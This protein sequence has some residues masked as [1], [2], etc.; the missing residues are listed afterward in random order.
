MRH[1]LI[2][3]G[4]LLLLA[5]AEGAEA[6]A[7]AEAEAADVRGAE[8][9]GQLWD[10]PCDLC[11]ENE[12]C[13]GGGCDCLEGFVRVEG[14]CQDVDECATDNGGCPELCENSPGAYV[15]MN[16]GPCP[17]CTLCADEDTILTAV[18]EARRHF[19]VLTAELPDAPIEKA[20]LEDTNGTLSLAFDAE[21]VPLLSSEAG[22]FAAA[23]RL[24]EGRVVAFSG[25]D[26]LSSGARSTLLDQPGV[27]GLIH[28]AADWVRGPAEGRQLLVDNQA[29]ADLL[30]DAGTVRVATIRRAEGL[31][32]IRDWSA[33][34][35]QEVDVAV[36]QV[37][38]WGTSHVEAADAQAL[39][40]FVRGGGGL[41]IAGSALHWSWWLDWTA[42]RFQGDAILEGSGLSWTKNSVRA[43]DQ[44]RFVND[45]LD[46]PIALWCGYVQGEPVADRLMPR[47]PPLFEAA[48]AE[49]LDAEVG[50]G[51]RRLIAETPLL[52]APR[53]SPAGLLSAEVGVGLRGAAW[54]S[55]HPWSSVFPG[56][57][58]PAA[59]RVSTTVTVN[60]DW[61][62]G[63][64]LGLYAPP[65]EVVEVQVAEAHIAQGL[66][67]RVGE[68]HDDN[69]FLEH[70]EAWERSPLLLQEG[71]LDAT[72]VRVGSGIGG[73]L[74]LV[75]PPEHPGGRI[76]LSVDGAVR[77]AVYTHGET[78]AGDF[79]AALDGGA[80]RALLQTVGK[81]RMEVPTAAARA[82]PDPAEVMDFWTG[83]YESHHSLAREPAP[84]S[85]ESHWL[86]D[87]QVGWGYANA[88]A[89]R[90]NFPPNAV[91]WAL[92]T[93]GDEDWWLFA[94]ELGHQFQTADWSG[95]DITEVAVNLFSM[96]T[97]NAYLNGGGA[98][99]TRGFMENRVDH[100]ALREARWETA[101][102]FGKLELYRQLVF[103]FGWPVFEQVFASYYDPAF[104]RETFGGFM[105]G[106]ALR[107]S[108]IARQDI[109][110]FLV[111]WGYPL[112]AEARRAVQSFGLP[113]WLPPGW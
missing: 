50:L 23:A 99:E 19:H 16:A 59:G 110:P 68:L 106:F 25:Q 47:L 18:A 17:G 72:T 46:T 37:N 39:N 75:V 61:K 15:C 69:R 33:A 100:A 81:V 62:L 64:P 107:F 14:R 113:E 82:V 35:L 63:R 10:V 1:A 70:I 71:P 52:P 30:A 43:V 36:V 13:R 98:R 76:E 48:H 5:C 44:A 26:F 94:H 73:T 77:Q 92:R 104:P 90:I 112:S 85:Y 56:Q 27:T 8:D 78:S 95:G 49:G 22:I 89:E 105:D 12:A 9:A 51:L 83:F 31:E 93:E 45:P 101:D 111:R 96:Y 20:L 57:V 97:I 7:E 28:N 11:P 87:V 2:L 91:G 55:P 21:V 40:D 74:Y 42:E 58:D 54:P 103:E 6:E 3:C 66:R 88:T 4:G 60:A 67:L 80:P 84:R 65:G 79:A 29:L 86:F 41:L 34:A 108:A 102:L 24:G 32:E 109:T 38:E 53:G